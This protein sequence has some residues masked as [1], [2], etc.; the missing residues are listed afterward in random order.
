MVLFSETVVLMVLFSPFQVRAFANFAIKE[1]FIG[2]WELWSDFDKESFWLFEP[3]SKLKTF[4]KYGTLI[5]IK[6]NITWL[7][8]EYK[9]NITWS[10]SNGSTWKPKNE[11]FIWLKNGSW[12]LV[13]ENFLVLGER[14]SKFLASAG[15]LILFLKRKS[16]RKS[17]MIGLIFKK[18]SL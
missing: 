15:P 18:N 10:N 12:Y 8:K 6:I 4:S 7:Y 2:L 11:V 3:L 16:W 14:M 9:V 17:I 5:K 1:I 13:E